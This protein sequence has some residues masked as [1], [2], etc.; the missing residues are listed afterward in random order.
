MV[1]RKLAPCNL[2][3]LYSKDTVDNIILILK[4]VRDINSGRSKYT[5]TEEL[6]AAK[7]SLGQSFGLERYGVS[8]YFRMFYMHYHFIHENDFQ[9]F[10]DIYDTEKAIETLLTG[11]DNVTN[12][13]TS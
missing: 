5:W 6:T 12:T 13:I 1:R 10:I 2:N 8:I 11:E 3:T 7:N 9:K 4:G